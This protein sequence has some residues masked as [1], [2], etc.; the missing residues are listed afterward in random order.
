MQSPLVRI[1]LNSILATTLA[2]ASLAAADSPEPGSDGMPHR[3][4]RAASPIVVD[5][6]LDEPA[7]GSALELRLAWEVW[8][9]DN[10]QAQVSTQA[11]LAFDSGKLYAAFRAHDPRPAEIRARLSDRD[12]AFQDDF[13]GLVI[14][15][16]NDE[17]RAFEFFVNALGVQM[18]LVQD[19][20]AGTEDS[21]WDAIW[22]AAGR[23]TE[24]GYVV[25]MAIP[26]TSLRFQRGAAEQVW[27]LDLIRIHPRD[28]RRLYALQ[29]RDRD[30]SCY[31]CQVQKVVGFEG[32]EPGRNLELAPTLT[33]LRTDLAGDEPG[34][35]EQG[36]VEAE[37][38]LT[39]RWGITP[40]LTAS[41][42]VNPDFSQV[43][44]DSGQLDVNQQ[45]ALFFP[46]KRPFFLEGADFF[47]TPLS[48]VYTRNVADPAWG[49]KLSGKEGR[50]ALGAFVAG[51]D[52][53]NLLIPGSERSRAGTVAGTKVTDAVLRYRRDMG[54]SSTL[55]A[56]FTSREGGGYSSSLLG[57]DTLLRL[58]EK[59]TLRAQVAG[60]RT[61]YPQDPDPNVT[62]ILTGLPDELIHDMAYYASYSH[63]AREGG[64]W[65]RYQD[66]GPDFRADMGFITRVGTRVPVLG[67]ERYWIGGQDD[68]YSRI[69]VGG[70]F[71]QTVDHSGKLLE[72]EV[73]AWGSV[74]GPMQSFLL[75]GGGQ[76]LFGLRDE[77][78]D[79]KF[80]NWYLEFQPAG[81][82][83]ASL[84]GGIS[85]RADLDFEDPDRPGAARQGRELRL[86]PWL[87]LSLGRNVRAELSHS[88]LTLDGEGGYFFRANLPQLNLAYQLSL[89][90]FLRAILQ[91]TDVR[92][93][94]AQYAGQCEAGSAF[95]PAQRERAAF[96]QL[97][98]SYKL[99][100]QSVIFLGYS[101]SR[102][103]ELDPA[104]G[105]LDDRLQA[106]D[107][108][109]FAKAG[110]AWVF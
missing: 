106:L 59:D 52:R 56:V 54:E 100:P 71:D 108:T 18:D 21:S 47:E 15:T 60:S 5:G 6:V 103:G 77:L 91:Y 74:N 27:G 17:R 97:L 37:P 78:F 72:R 75:V 58:G 90:A 109:F 50:H 83:Y 92:R 104:R 19:D 42:A 57:V 98:F 68:W 20:V 28:R 73:E 80:V 49:A 31:L 61:L 29:R 35:L 39:A 33:A 110:Y 25:E 94:A 10:A 53:L 107:R 22:D 9:A 14:D 82:L 40:N 79:Q 55:G 85:H 88:Y 46:E 67:T 87:R 105:L 62:S 63:F 4:P 48:T 38:G 30:V 96:V 81:W 2:A 12:R 89:R 13:V 23:V 102:S 34:D 93:N 66:L 45:F 65:A 101:S 43:E 95:C 69:T 32:A 3:V 11:L 41:A 64:F 24:G 8:P 86:S 16:F 7:W 44:A 84:D 99:N 70:D 76:R 51:D 26:Y 1:A 36:G